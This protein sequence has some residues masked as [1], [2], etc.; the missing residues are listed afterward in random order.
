MRASLL[1]CVSCFVF[2]SGSALAGDS[3]A[4]AKQIMDQAGFTGGFVVHV[5]CGNAELTEKLRTSS[6]G[7][8]HGLDL[9]TE[10][11]D[12]ARTRLRKAG[13]YGPISVDVWKGGRLPYV[14]NMITL[15]V[16]ETPVIKGEALRV[17]APNGV[18]LTRT[19]DG[20]KKLTKPKPED[21]DD[22][23]HYLHD[24]SGNAVSHDD[25]VAPPR[26][27]QW[28][29]SPRWSRHHDR[30][31]SM[32]ALV[33]AGGRL[34]YIM[35]E[36]SRIS[37][38]LP[39]KWKLV[40]RDAYN[41]TI[42]WKRDIGKWQSHL[43]P[44][45]SGP[46]NLAR[47]LVAIENDVFATLGITDPVS[48]IDATTGET[49]RV[50]DA[51]KGA[52]E[53][54][55]SNGVLLA[56]CN[57]GDYVLADFAPKLNTGDQ[58]RVAKDF[59]WNEKE[60]EIVAVDVNTGNVL[61]K[62]KT[63]VSPLSLSSNGN[64]TLFHDG[65]RL[66]CL[67]QKTGDQS[68]ATDPVE[69]RSKITFNFGPKL[70]LYEDVVLFAGGDRKMHA[71]QAASGD[72]LWSAPHARS[73][74]QSPEDLL[75]AGGLVWNAPTTGSGDSGEF[76]GRDPKTG[77]IKKQFSPDVETY[78]FHHRCYIAKATDNYLIP[79]RTGIEFVDFNKED[80][81]INHWVRG[82][83]LYGSM[84]CNGLLYAPPHN[85]A[86]YP[87]AKLY[88]F[89]ALAPASTSRANLKRTPEAERLYVPPATRSGRGNE[90][91][92]RVNGTGTRSL[93]HYEKG[94]NTTEDWPTYRHNPE[95]TAFATTTVSTKPKQQW[96]AKFN[97]R[98]SA[99]VSA[100]GHVFV[101]EIDAHTVHAINAKTGKVTWSF[102]TGA[103]VDSPPTIAGNKAVFGSA[104]GHVYCVRATDGQLLWRYQVAPTDQRLMSFEQ[105]ESVWPVHGNV[106]I[107]D[108]VV[109][110][111]AG[112][113]N[114]LDGGLTMVRLKVESGEKISETAIDETDPNTGKNL[115]DGLQILQMA[116]GLPDILS[117]NGDS[118]FMRSQKFSLDGNR[119]DIGPNSGDFAGQASVHEGSDAHV[120]AP[121]G[122]LDDTW[123]HRSYW[124]FGRSFAGGHAGYYQ[125]GRFAP[126]GR[127]LVFDENKVYGFGRKPEY[128]KWTTTLEHQLFAADREAPVV[129]DSAKRRRRGKRGSMIKVA[130]SPSLDPT[131][132]P[133]AVEA[134]VRA[135]RPNGTILAHGG[136]AQGYA[137][138]LKGG[139]PQFHVRSGDALATANASRRITNRWAH[140]V[141]LINADKQLEIY[142]DGERVGQAAGDFAGGNPAQ[143]LEIGS[144][145]QSAV[146]EYKSPNT[147][148]GIVDNVR[149]F[150]GSLTAA[151]VKNLAAG[152]EATSDNIKL[153]AAWTFD[154]GKPN[155]SSG[156]RNRGQN[157][158]GA[159]VAGKLGGA[160]KFAPNG[161]GNSG[162]K[163]T[164]VE[165]IWTKDI[166]LLARAML[167]TPG[168]NKDTDRILFVAGPPDIIDEEETFKRLTE[169]DQEVQ[170][171]LAKQDA[172]L[173]GKDGGLLRVINGETG[174]TLHEV[175][176]DYLPAWD[177]MIAASGQLVVVTT[178]GRVV[179]LR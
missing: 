155:D 33:S 61:W 15:L 83:C 164:F 8:V 148:N 93:V 147:L 58:G 125:A 160:W 136:P 41:G 25:Q 17:L 138:T 89:N 67:D 94:S 109:F 140:V 146:G 133:L 52:E 60:R 120:F 27:L 127:I 87:E 65:T 174:E 110:A 158:G 121:M 137:L 111:V 142:V 114:F 122:F 14:D 71:Y 16:I 18:A 75:V 172:A 29:G 107:Q 84:P 88:G 153:A 1:S 126:A 49:K 38:Q 161:G 177:G 143:G 73:G 151:D 12:A 31:A 99:P 7:T 54:I 129:P 167:L 4:D 62:Q 90:S 48:H 34:F 154:S 106:L 3:V 98:L 166:P 39:P 30:M 81:D 103:R 43:W 2:L 76:I 119:M 57:K 50:F 116:V 178:D 104:D 159:A 165:H 9:D 139:K 19:D 168:K 105:L 11:I 82:G 96:E 173:E 24:A 162:N 56:L 115:Q 149:V 171:L 95:R 68:W 79:S 23:T 118:V 86:C 35:D 128:L 134:W 22:W 141:G 37:I 44:L 179:S 113:S 152:K 74:Y 80:W 92:T 100:A 102:T 10:N 85:C 157:E 144:D 53:I 175:K 36:G 77:E 40:G 108:G 117:S 132:K 123:F 70:V 5:G 130:K 46:T 124:V 63:I 66:V 20:W 169:K 59:A 170:R 13:K 101:A 176:T 21:I 150:H 28:L 51:T 112:R 47:R 32:S 145:D 26:H 163:P 42:L 91:P 72:E 156:N 131:N 45:K 6:F 97:G 78:W 64:Q 135:L 55:V 69:R